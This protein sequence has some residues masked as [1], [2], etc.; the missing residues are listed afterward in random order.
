[1]VPDSLEGKVRVQEY[2]Q[3]GFV[4]TQA[5][6]SGLTFG[7]VQQLGQLSADNSGFMQLE[8][9][10]AGDLVTLNGRVDLQ[11][12]PTQGS[13]VQFTIAFPARVATTNGTREGDS[14]VSWKLP[15]GEVT[16][17]RAEVRYVDPNTRSFAGWAGIVGGVT[18]GVAAIIAAMAYMNRNPRP[19]RRA[20]QKQRV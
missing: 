6:F 13:D 3:D 19:H 14:I 11:S 1:M 7:D 10:R 15:P 20:R 9:R 18:I 5:F 2:A 8:L 4:G 17:L 12:V 16:S